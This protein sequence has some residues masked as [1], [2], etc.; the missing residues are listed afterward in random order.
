M[1]KNKK[2]DKFI[3][4]IDEVGR[5]AIAGPLVLGAAA[6]Y[7]NNK[8]KKFLTGIKDSKKLTFNQRLLWYKKFKDSDL[9]FYCVFISNNFIDK[10]GMSKSLKEGVKRLLKK[11]D[12][13]IDLVLLDGG[14]KAPEK[15]KQKTI[16][17]GDDKVPFISAASIYAKVKRDLYMIRMD[18]KIN[19]CFTDHKGYGTK[20]HFLLIKKNGI[21]KVH[22]KTFLKNIVKK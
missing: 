6:G 3:V 20:K 15:Y 8:N 22:R 5:G 21:S 10:Y 2:N 18:K 11:I 7:L 16:I 12:K 17:R 4:G 14:L 1:I 19:Y 13:K 9:N